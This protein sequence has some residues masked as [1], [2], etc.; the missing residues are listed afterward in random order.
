MSKSRL[1]PNTWPA[2]T[3]SNVVQLETGGF[4]RPFLFLLQFVETALR[5]C[6]GGADFTF[7]MRG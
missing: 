7:A 2:C 6:D 3:D 5:R 4:G 1:L